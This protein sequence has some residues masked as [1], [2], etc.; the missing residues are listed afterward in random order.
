MNTQRIPPNDHEAE[1]ACICAAIL[2][3]ERIAASALKPHHF[4]SR[5]HEALWSAIQTAHANGNVDAVAVASTL[6]ATGRAGEVPP[7]YL[8]EILGSAACMTRAAWDAYETAVIDMHARREAIKRIQ[9]AEAELYE[10]IEGSTSEYCQGVAKALLDV[11]AGKPI[12]RR[13]T[14]DA[15]VR[16]YVVDAKLRAK[17]RLSTG[18][19]SLDA[20][21]G[22][23]F[24]GDLT[25]IAGRPGMGKTS[26][27]AQMCASVA[28]S[29][30][31]PLF[32]SLE[33][34]GAE[35]FG[36]ALAGA[37]GVPF[38]RIRAGQITPG[39]HVPLQRGSEAIREAWRRVGVVEMFG[40][41]IEDVRRAVTEEAANHG[42]VH[43]LAIDYLQLMALQ[44][45][46][47]VV[48]S[49]QLITKGLKALAKEMQ[50]PIVLLSQ[51]NRGVEARDNKRPSMSDL[52][53]SGSIEQDADNVILIYR[54]GYYSSP[55]E[56]SGDA[57]LD[58]A[59]CRNGEPQV[60]ATHWDGPRTSFRDVE[61]DR[62]EA[63]Q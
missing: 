54:A 14:Y 46:R 23:L 30:K 56:L 35:V 8:F 27:V 13:V 49:I 16:G 11:T 2:V 57:E 42:P 25:V 4:Y 39:D 29:G 59:K 26:M 28:A 7:G 24:P 36:R 34:P 10:G 48:N 55:K 3:P 51:L 19:P 62:A 40:P 61:F 37:S 58:L 53:A 38:S 5:K 22:G 52:R 45:E 20:A 43:L 31:H 12:N 1:A 15:S 47:D 6:T 63:A 32:L 18:L 33:M 9:R 21:M 17:T 41:S 44:N 50:V 60:V